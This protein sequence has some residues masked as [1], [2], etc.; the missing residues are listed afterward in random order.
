MWWARQT[1]RCMDY[2]CNCFPQML[3]SCRYDWDFLVSCCFLCRWRSWTESHFFG[4]KNI[5]GKKKAVQLTG[6]W[7]KRKSCFFLMYVCI[8]VQAYTRLSV[9]VDQRFISSLQMLLWAWAH[10]RNPQRAK[11]DILN[12]LITP[13][14]NLPSK[15][16]LLSSNGTTAQNSLIFFHVILHKLRKVFKC[17]S[18]VSS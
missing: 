1:G 16:N 10:M 17:S 7:R 15:I 3:F 9:L 11:S 6:V 18:K 13:K 12:K 14:I 8:G 2:I 4:T 5:C